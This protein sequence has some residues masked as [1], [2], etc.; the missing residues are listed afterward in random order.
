VTAE[1]RVAWTVVATTDFTAEIRNLRTTLLSIQAVSDPTALE[2]KIAQLSDMASAPDLWDD[3]DAA[4]KVTSALS[5]SQAEL[6]RVTK[7][8]ARIDDLETLVE[9]ANEDGIAG[10]DS[11]DAFVEAE[12][13][14]EAIRTDLG[15]L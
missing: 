10:A 13:D 15:E 1:D 6:D 5:A 12:A 3:P 2:A 9:M 11:V 8:G 4:Q 14:L 7:L